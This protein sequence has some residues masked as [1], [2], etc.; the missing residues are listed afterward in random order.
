VRKW[1]CLEWGLDSILGA[2]GFQIRERCCVLLAF[3]LLVLVMEDLL[4]ESLETAVAI[5][6]AGQFYQFPICEVVEA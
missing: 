3:D 2:S 4:D 5:A 1:W 6:V